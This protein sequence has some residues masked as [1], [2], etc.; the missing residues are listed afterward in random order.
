ML[1]YIQDFPTIILNYLEVWTMFAKWIRRFFALLVALY[2]LILCVAVFYGL[3]AQEIS[4]VAGGMVIITLFIV[5]IVDMIRGISE[6]VAEAIRK[7]KNTPD[8]R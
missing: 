7:A 4:E 1:V 5:V 8:S 3:G 2:I 6:T